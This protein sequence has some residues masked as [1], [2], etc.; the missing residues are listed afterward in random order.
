MICKAHFKVINKQIEQS[1]SSA[2]QAQLVCLSDQVDQTK[3]DGQVLKQ[4][5]VVVLNHKAVFTLGDRSFRWEYPAN[6]PHIA[7]LAKGAKSPK[8]TPKVL[9]PTNRSKGK[10]SQHLSQISFP[11]RKTKF[12]ST[13][14]SKTLKQV[15][16]RVCSL[17]S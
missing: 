15:H 11:P 4:N 9:S 13:D 10:C 6:S 7:T 1:W 17:I 8:K 5:T 3:V 2:F 12:N 16:F 14:F